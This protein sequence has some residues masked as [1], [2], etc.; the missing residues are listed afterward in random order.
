[1]E[2]LTMNVNELAEAMGISRPKAYELVKQE[3][4]PRVIIGKRIVI[5]IESFR[6]WL[7]KNAGA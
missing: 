1:M 3:G 7:N 4:F 5:P 2:R 6:D